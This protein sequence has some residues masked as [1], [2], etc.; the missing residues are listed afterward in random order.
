MRAEILKKAQ[1][2]ALS[3]IAPVPYASAVAFSHTVGFY[4]ITARLRDIRQAN[5]ASLLAT[6]RTV[7]G[8]E[9]AVQESLALRA[10]D[11]KVT[12]TTARR[13][14]CHPADAWLA[15]HSFYQTLAGVTSEETWDRQARRR[16]RAEDGL[17]MS[18]RGRWLSATMTR[19]S[20]SA[21]EAAL[22]EKVAAQGWCGE[23]VLHGLAALPQ[24]VPQ[25]HRW[26]LFKAH[27]R[28]HLTT[29][30]LRHTGIVQGVERCPF[31]QTA[32][33]SMEH[34]VDCD[35]VREALAT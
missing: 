27:M 32:E 20:S 1:A 5:V 8:C 35:T 29:S 6:Y 4:G 30:R 33:D 21:G 28:G 18:E 26:H 11:E 14:L 22:C 7:P 2:G 12:L 16:R 9:E 15:A 13:R 10:H 34:I 25:G 24:A 31:C 19:V 17:S 23:Q 3:L